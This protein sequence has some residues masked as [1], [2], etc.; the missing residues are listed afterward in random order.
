MFNLA[1]KP[2]LISTNSNEYNFLMI[3]IIEVDIRKTMTY[4]E[5]MFLES[6]GKPVTLT[7]LDQH[8]AATLAYEDRLNRLSNVLSVVS[9]IMAVCAID[10]LSL[11]RM[12]DNLKQIAIRK[13]FGASD[14]QI[15][16]KLSVRF[17]ELMIGA[18][19]F[20]G[21]LTYLLLIEWL[22]NFAYAARFSWS[23]PLVSIG[24]CLVVVAITNLMLLRRLNANVLRE[25][26]RR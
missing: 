20:F 2:V 4:I 19:F 25:L 18:I 9:L 11:S 14:F 5:R 16:R 23:D 26:L 13:T 12:A 24:C 15:V 21:P 22:R 1:D 7:F 8:Y 17:L 3:R 6:Y 10:A